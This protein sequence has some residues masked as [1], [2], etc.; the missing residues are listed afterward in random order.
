MTLVDAATTPSSASSP[1]VGNN[2]M[3]GAVAGIMVSGVLVLAR[4][5]TGDSIV[6]RDQVE[7]IVK[8]SMG[9]RL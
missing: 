6:H 8:Q 1:I 2:V 9:E 7:D 5:I 4:G 3:L